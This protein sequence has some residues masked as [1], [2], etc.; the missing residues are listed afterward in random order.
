MTAQQPEP[1]RAQR[2]CD[3]CHV[4]DDLGHHQVAE[5]DAEGNLSVSSRHFACCAAAGCP[6][7]SCDAI[8]TGEPGV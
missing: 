8:L 2:E 6:D 7:Q 3:E 5:P 4:V 1:A